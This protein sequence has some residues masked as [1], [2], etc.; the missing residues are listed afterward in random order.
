MMVFKGG[1]DSE[2]TLHI[3][4]IFKEKEVTLVKTKLENHKSK[5][6]LTLGV[7]LPHFHP[8][9]VSFKGGDIGRGQTVRGFECK[10]YTCT[11][12]KDSL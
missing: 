3:N 5:L 9:K 8:N 1:Q 7:V 4:L 6:Q 11:V 10:F 12:Y 2:R